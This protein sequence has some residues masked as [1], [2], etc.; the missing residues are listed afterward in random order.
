MTASRASWMAAMESLSSWA[1]QANSQ[2]PPPIAH[3]PK[4]IGVM[5]RSE[6]PSCLVSMIS[7]SVVYLGFSPLPLSQ[8][9]GRRGR[10]VEARLGRPCFDSLP[11]QGACQIADIG[12]IP[13]F[14]TAFLSIVRFGVTFVGRFLARQVTR[15]PVDG[16]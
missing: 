16:L 4:P 7:V 9:Q 15:V 8:Q 12:E 3:A 2:P 10:C 1:P 14:S 11:K 5:F 13:H 6:V